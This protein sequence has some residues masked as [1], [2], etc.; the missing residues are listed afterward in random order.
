MGAQ[1]GGA[2]VVIG[3]WGAAGGGTP[4]QRA[5]LA[6]PA[7]FGFAKGAAPRPRAKHLSF[8]YVLGYETNLIGTGAEKASGRGIGT[9]RKK[10]RRKAC[11]TVYLL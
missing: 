10:A 7:A 4:P 9:G 11:L 5:P 2:C 8:R 1:G 6:E 3:R